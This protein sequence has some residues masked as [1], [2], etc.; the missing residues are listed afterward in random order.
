MSTTCAPSVLTTPSILLRVVCGRH[1]TMATFSPTSALMSVDLP[2]LGMPAMHIK[3]DLIS[4]KFLPCVY[5]VSSTL[6]M[7]LSVT[8]R[9]TRSSSS[10]MWSKPSRCSSP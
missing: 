9:M 3:P 10:F 6:S 4:E 2:A 5:L 8:A 1:E 7:T